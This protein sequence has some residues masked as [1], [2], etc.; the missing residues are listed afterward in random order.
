MGWL[1]GGPGEGGHSKNLFLKSCKNCLA[2]PNCPNAVD[3]LNES[4]L[5]FLILS[6]YPN[7][8]RI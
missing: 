8:P 5:V 7:I 4:R 6:S 3:S 1:R 2:Q